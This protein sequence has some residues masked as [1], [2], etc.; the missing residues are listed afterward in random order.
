ML[1]D[2][3]AFSGFSSNDIPKAMEFYANTLGLE[4]TEQN[5]M[6]T[7]NLAGGGKVLIY[8]KD[9]HEP[10]SFTVLN[11][12]VKDID[13]AVDGLTKAGVEFER[14]EGAGQDER[15]IAREYPPPIAWFKDPAGNILAVLE[16]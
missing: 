1:K 12:P 15:G 6:L 10:A 9:D 14:Y 16:G 4:V 3:H 7:L 13:A 11:F 8:P 2:S 5:G